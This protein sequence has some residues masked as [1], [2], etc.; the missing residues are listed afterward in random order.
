[1]ASAAPSRLS[2]P[3]ISAAMVSDKVANIA[4]TGATQVVSGDIGYVMKYLGR[5]EEGQDP[6]KGRHIA[7]FGVSASAEAGAA[8]GIPAVCPA[9]RYWK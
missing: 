7:E 1:M 9:P 3:E 8:V 6:V 4:A 5:H 2:L